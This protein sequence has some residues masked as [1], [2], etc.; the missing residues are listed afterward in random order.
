M[1]HFRRAVGIA[2]ALNTAIA[3]GEA[4]AGF[5][6][7][8]LSLMLDAAHNLS[9]ELAL[10]CLFL[11]F[12]LSES[13]SRHSQRLANVLNSGGLI[14]LSAAILWQG[15]LRLAHP[16]PVSGSIA[17]ACGLAAAAAN[18][19]V[20][21][22]LREVARSNV[23]ARLAYL[24][25]L[26]DVWISLAPALSGLLVWLSGHSEADSIVALLMGTWL[27]LSTTFEVKK[28]ANELLWPTR[29]G[30]DHELTLH[31]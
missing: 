25:N 30:C 10:V 5:R 23:T 14:V 29:L 12:F 8:S 11:A 31:R 26:G 16:V 28:S 27:A 9:D 17:I 6:S 21:M 18:L 24:H 22:A 7:G 1:S 19:G 2:V 15:G 3:A 4:F 20:A 13:M